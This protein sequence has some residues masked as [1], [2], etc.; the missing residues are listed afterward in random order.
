MIRKWKLKTLLNC[1]SIQERSTEGQ[2]LLWHLCRHFVYAHFRR[3]P[4]AVKPLLKTNESLPLTFN[5]W[6]GLTCLTSSSSQEIRCLTSGVYLL[7]YAFC[8]ILESS[9]VCSHLSIN[10]FRNNIYS[11]YFSHVSSCTSPNVGTTFCRDQETT[12]QYFMPLKGWSESETAET[13][14]I[15]SSSLIVNIQTCWLNLTFSPLTS[16]PFLVQ[17]AKEKK[18]KTTKRKWKWWLIDI[19]WQQ[20]FRI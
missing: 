6:P 12:D 10:T 11:H 15:H 18:K 5:L 9:F 3:L 7:S 8:F 13:Q 16:K 14:S 17:W 2:D 19:E 1:S 4:L 20:W